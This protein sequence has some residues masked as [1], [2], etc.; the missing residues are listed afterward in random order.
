MPKTSQYLLEY[1]GKV[2]FN[3]SCQC[4][5]S[6]FFFKCGLMKFQIRGHSGEK[7]MLYILNSWK[8]IES[9]LLLSEINYKTRRL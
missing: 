7:G 4:T 6:I 2:E 8:Y 9:V 3:T 5:V 1:N